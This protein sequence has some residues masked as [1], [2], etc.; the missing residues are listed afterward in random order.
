VAH[1]FFDHI[2]RLHDIPCSI[3]NDRDP[4]FTSTFW[5]ELFALSGVDL[6]LSSTFHPQT[7]GQ[8]EVTNRV[9]GIYLRCLAGDRPRSWLHWLPWAEYCYNTSYQMTPHT[10]PFQVVYGRAP[11]TMSSYQPG[12]RVATLDKQLRDHDAFLAEIRERL[13][14]ARDYMKLQYDA[15]HRDIQF[16]IGYWWI[17]GVAPSAPSRCYWHHQQEHQ[18]TVTAL[19]W[20]ISGRR[21]C[22]PSGVSSSAATQG[23]VS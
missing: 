6:R 22:W 17:L 3:V 15:G 23:K 2:V 18:Q 9:L 11:P 12:A 13:L 5:T 16:N 20:P 19:L 7:D 8:S 21:S 1:V 14:H 4:V 10:T